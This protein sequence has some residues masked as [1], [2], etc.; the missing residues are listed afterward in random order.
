MR[1][2]ILALCLSVSGYC[3]D[4]FTITCTN[5]QFDLPHITTIVNTNTV[6]SNLGLASI[7]LT[8]LDIPLFV[9]VFTNTADT[10]QQTTIA[11]ILTNYSYASFVA[12]ISYFTSSIYLSNSILYFNGIA[13]ITNANQA[14]TNVSGGIVTDAEARAALNALLAVARARGWLLP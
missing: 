5:K 13:V 1:G 8:A 14:I 3:L 12:P 9:F 6:T 7:S 11:N 2:I 4:V 10:N